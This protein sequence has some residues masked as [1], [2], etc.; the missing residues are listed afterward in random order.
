MPYINDVTLMGHLGKDPNVKTLNSGG[1]IATFSV[2]TTE[3]WKDKKSGEKKERT[4]WHLIKWWSDAKY[5]QKG[6]LV[7]VKGKLQT[8]TYEKEGETK[9]IT[10]VQA[11][12]VAAIS[13]GKQTESSRG[14]YNNDDDWPHE[15]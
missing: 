11:N 15:E 1:T 8:D 13:G 6:T 9:S 4:T 3:Y 14:G 7:L 2:A 12:Y 5:L 10:Y